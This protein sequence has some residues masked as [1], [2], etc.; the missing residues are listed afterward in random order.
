MWQ[1]K[2]ARSAVS[3]SGIR[4][5]TWI[6]ASFAVLAVLTGCMTVTVQDSILIN[7]S[8]AQDKPIR[9]GLSTTGEAIGEVLKAAGYGNPI[10]LDAIKTIL[11]EY[12]KIKAMKQQESRVHPID[13]RRLRNRVA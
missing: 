4:A 5:V 2:N 1:A 12:R 13:W 3:V 11:E 10:D 8:V 6:A 7:S 9:A